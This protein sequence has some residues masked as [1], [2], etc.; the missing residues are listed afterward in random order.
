MLLSTSTIYR[1]DNP[2]IDSFKLTRRIYK[3]IR[4][5][6][7]QVLCPPAR[8]ANTSSPDGN[9]SMVKE[10]QLGKLAQQRKRR[11][12]ERT[13]RRQWWT[14]MKPG[15]VC[16]PLSLTMTICRCRR[17]MTG[18]IAGCRCCVTGR[19]SMSC[20]QRP[21]VCLRCWRSTGH[22][23]DTAVRRPLL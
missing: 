18:T 3:E 13:R 21:L 8:T 1:S 22:R 17:E 16:R 5:C 14:R 6:Q 7:G 4:K 11:R 20:I 15:K 2:D 10:V 23:W 9:R 12:I 19:W